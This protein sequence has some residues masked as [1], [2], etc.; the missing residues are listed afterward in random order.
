[1]SCRRAFW[2]RYRSEKGLGIGD[3]ALGEEEK[4]STRRARRWDTEGRGGIREKKEKTG[5]RDEKCRCGGVE[6]GLME[7]RRNGCWLSVAR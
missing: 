3:W 2:W 6:E 5:S 7:F 1:L 4:I